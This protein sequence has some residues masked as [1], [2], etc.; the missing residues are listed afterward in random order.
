MTPFR[1]IEFSDPAIAADGLAFATVK[2]A[3]LGQRADICFYVPPGADGLRDLPIVVLMHGVYGSHWAWA[4]KGAAHVTAARLIASGAVPPMVL[5]MPSDG[6]WGDG[7]GYVRHDG[8]DGGQDFERWIVEEVPAAA[9]Q[10]CGG[11]SAQSPLLLAGLSMGGFAALR[12]AGKYADR[13]AA[14]AAHSA[15]TD[16]AELDSL[17]EETRA[18]WSALPGDRTVLAALTGAG[19][20]LPPLRFDCGR[21]D[22]FIESNRALHQ[23]LEARGIDHVYA[24]AQGGHEWSYWMR[25]FEQTLRFFGDVLGRG[26]PTTGQGVDR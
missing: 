11:C 5:A 21:D 24:E 15:V 18:D 4:L 16:V 10:L 1:T 9:A 13:V 20:T 23:A 26:Q 22:P 12:L 2:S 8:E 25:E 3:A 19:T 17:I 14:A 7:S 6:L